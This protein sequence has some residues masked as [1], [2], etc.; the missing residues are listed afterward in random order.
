[1]R[2]GYSMHDTY[3]KEAGIYI[4]TNKIN[5]KVYVGE[6]MNIYDR[7]SRHRLMKDKTYF[8]NALRKYGWENFQ[9]EIEYFP[10]FCK[11]N[12][13]DL[14]EELI[15]RFNSLIPQGYNI[16]KRG[17]DRTGVKASAETRKKM[18]DALKGRIFS[19][20]T[21]KKLS[22]DKIGDKS[23]CYNKTGDKCPNS[24]PVLQYDKDGGFI[25]EFSCLAEVERTLGIF[26]AN[27]SRCCLNKRGYKTA[28]GFIWRYVN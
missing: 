19:E 18:S 12:L 26:K 14:E 1:M 10:N 15:K 24:K 5:G 22:D 23:Y 8:H 13:L 11:I 17:T 7:M 2:A 27:V 16:C 6:T 21:R 28:G 20:E 9:I 3:K 4:F 25:K